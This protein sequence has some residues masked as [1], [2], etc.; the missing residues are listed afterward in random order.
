MH[1]EDSNAGRT[2][3]AVSE[4]IKG[5]F[6]NVLHHADQL[7]NEE[8]GWIQRKRSIANSEKKNKGTHFS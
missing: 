5:V 7:R 2:K 8:A 3:I 1:E 4:E 6:E